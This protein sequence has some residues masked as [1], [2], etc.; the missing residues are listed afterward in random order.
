M[1]WT[2]AIAIG[3]HLDLELQGVRGDGHTF[4]VRVIGEAEAG[5]PLSS[6][7]TGTLQDITVRKQAEE[8]LR[9]QAR[10]DPLTGLL[11]R[12]AR[13]GRAGGP[14]RRSHPIRRWRCSTSTSTASRWSTTCSAMP[15][16]TACWRP[17]HA[18]SSAR[19]A[20]KA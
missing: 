16:A 10:T 13:A 14:P 5:D 7:L 4:W 2:Q 1:A 20:A 11:N 17:P 12:D 9:V 6:R 19:S 3:H 15:P 18:A 8:T